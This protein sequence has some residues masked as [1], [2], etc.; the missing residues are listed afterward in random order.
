MFLGVGVAAYAA[1]IFHLV[2]HA[3]FK[4]L[5]FLGAGSVIHAL[6]GE[7]DM[8][9]M[10]GLKQHLPVTYWTMLAGCLAIAGIPPLAGFIS[11]DEIL[12]KTWES[13]NVVLWAIG[14]VTAGLT[15]FYMFRLF[16]LTF[17]GKFRGTE[18]QR[19]RVH[20]SPASMGVPLIILAILSVI[21][22]WMGLPAAIGNF[23]G[24]VPNGF[25]AWLAP[26]FE[27]GGHGEVEH[28]VHAIPPAE[29]GL[30][31]ASVAVATIG[32]LTAGWFYVR[33]PSL[34]GIVAGRFHGVYR[35]LLE[36][37][38]VDEAYD[39]LVVRPYNALSNF[40]WRTVDDGFIDGLGVNGSGRLIRFGSGV[41]SR[42]Q[43]GLV[44]NYLLV[45]FAGVL[46]IVTW[47]LLV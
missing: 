28:A 34:P 46:A 14:F 20:E 6:H 9:N 8:R 31:V 32:I 15:A 2:T 23:L 33:N 44:T 37:Y 43:T 26:V 40:A 42:W 27:A 16:F 39:L 22:G 30:M 29:Y 3:F 21:G 1:G 13:G 45:F 18:E 11:K 10:G 35:L 17:H 41:A 25:E 47:Y 4:A 19:A 5:L 36:K 24:N 12:W 38:W 7:Q